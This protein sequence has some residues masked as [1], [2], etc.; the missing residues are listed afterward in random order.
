ME[1]V[2]YI[3]ESEEFER[4]GKFLV[5]VIYDIIENNKRVRFSKFLES[6]GVRIQKSAFEVYITQ[7]LYEKLIKEIP[8]RI[9]QEDNVRV[10]KIYENNEILQFGVVIDYEKEDTIIF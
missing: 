4:E 2:D 9:S 5:L 1:I 8:K 7:K 10:Y 6:Y 3:V